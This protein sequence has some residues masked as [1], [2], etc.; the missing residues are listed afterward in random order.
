MRNAMSQPVSPLALAG[1]LA[2]SVLNDL[3]AKENGFKD[4]LIVTD[5]GIVSAIHGPV[6]N[7]VELSLEA[8]EKAEEP[9]AACG[10]FSCA[11]P[12]EGEPSEDELFAQKIEEYRTTDL[13]AL[14]LTAEMARAIVQV[15]ELR[16]YPLPPLVEAAFDKVADRSEGLTETGGTLR[17]N[18][19]ALLAFLMVVLFNVNAKNYAEQGF[20]EFSALKPTIH[21][22]IE[23]VGLPMLDAMELFVKKEVKNIGE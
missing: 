20:T 8:E 4:V 11:C 23:F 13:V 3:Q 17:L 16:S 19:E 10:E 1:L 5:E 18:G 7:S 9:C 6:G 15:A 22:L 14:H 2:C 12:G 21:E